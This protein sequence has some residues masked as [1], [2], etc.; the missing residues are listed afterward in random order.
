LYLR[1][2]FDGSS[3][4]LGSFCPPGHPSGASEQ[5]PPSQP[6]PGFDPIGFAVIQT[7]PHFPPAL[8]LSG[9]SSPALPLDFGLWALD[10]GLSAPPSPPSSPPRHAPLPRPPSVAMLPLYHEP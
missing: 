1:L 5:R 4:D 2:Y 9:F 3:K 6:R 7:K 8:I 10:F